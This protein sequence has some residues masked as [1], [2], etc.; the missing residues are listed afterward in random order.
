MVTE[1]GGAWSGMGTLR[2]ER[3]K[4]AERPRRPAYKIILFIFVHSFNLPIPFP[5]YKPEIE[6]FICLSLFFW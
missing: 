5:N 2:S 4:G 3:T 1:E 6:K